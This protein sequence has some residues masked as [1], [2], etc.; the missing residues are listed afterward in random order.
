MTVVVNMRDEGG[1]LINKEE[2]P[3]ICI[4]A[5]NDLALDLLILMR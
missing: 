5:M 3:L 4:N 1:Y 2:S